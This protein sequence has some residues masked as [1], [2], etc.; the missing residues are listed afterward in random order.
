MLHEMFEFNDQVYSIFQAI[1][2]RINRQHKPL[3]Q[4]FG[5]D[6]IWEVAFAHATY[7]AERNLEEIGSSDISAWVRDITR[8]LEALE[9]FNLLEGV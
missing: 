4:Q 1:L 2:H 7:I 8:S 6:K 3:I 5:T 9:Q